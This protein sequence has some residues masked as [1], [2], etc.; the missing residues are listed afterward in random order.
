MDGSQEVKP[1]DRFIFTQGEDVRQYVVP[2]TEDGYVTICQAD[3][4][5]PELG[6]SPAG[7]VQVISPGGG[8]KDTIVHLQN[9]ETGKIAGVFRRS[10]VGGGWSGTGEWERAA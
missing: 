2:E 3:P 10:L 8:E 1:G 9:V 4:D 7:R 6:V 5:R